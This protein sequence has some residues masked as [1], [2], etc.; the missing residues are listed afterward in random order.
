M[1]FV[2]SVVPRALMWTKRRTPASRAASRSARRATAHH[3]FELRPLA[4]PDR[5]EVHDA[6]DA[7]DRAPERVRLRHVALDELTAEALEL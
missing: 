6:L 2:S 5:H 7:V 3:G 1:S 4:L